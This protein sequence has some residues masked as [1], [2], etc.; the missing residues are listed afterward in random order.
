MKDCYACR[1][2]KKRDKWKDCAGHEWYHFREICYCSHQVR[3][4]IEHAWLLSVGYW[5]DVDPFINPEAQS[6]RRLYNA[7]FI[8]AI[9]TVAD[10]N[11]RLKRAGKD[12]RELRQSIR[13]GKMDDELSYDEKMAFRYVTGWWTKQTPYRLFKAMRKYR[14]KLKE[15]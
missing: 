9:E 15:A 2:E 8:R 3:W 14:R 4:I 12:G 6:K 1:K 7:P 5:P 10:I 13:E 11:Y